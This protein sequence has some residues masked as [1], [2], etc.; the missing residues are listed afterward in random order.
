MTS[1][2]AR[3]LEGMRRVIAYEL[4]SLDGV[5]ES[6]DEFIDTW[7]DVLDANL[8]EVIGTQTDVVLGRRSHDEWA[9][10]WPTSDVEPFATFINAVPKHVATSTPLPGGWG[11]VAIEGDV[12]SFVRGLR[13][14]DGGDIGVHAS[15]SLVQTL[16]AADLVDELRL[17]VAPAVAGKGR[18]LL[19]G[20][21]AT[22]LELVRS[23]A[24]PTGS[25]L[26]TYRPRR[27]A[28]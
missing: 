18:R 10:Y 24:T 26:L 1:A 14:S 21:P 15:I 12:A 6:P 25:L 20:V 7:D 19:D 5:A 13:A 8:A 23:Q 16:L 3:R 9:H 17:V 28:D 4:L 11:A 2:P 22:R 27:L